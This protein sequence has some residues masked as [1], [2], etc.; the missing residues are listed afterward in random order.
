MEY[1]LV[2]GA[3]SALHGATRDTQDVDILVQRTPAN[4]DRLG[5]ALSEL[6]ARLRAEGL[7][8]EVA[9]A[10]PRR[11]D[12]ATLER[13]EIATLRT[14]CGDLDVLADI[15]GQG[16]RRFTY[17]DLAPDAL[18]VQASPTLFVRLASVQAIV[19]SKEWADRPKDREALPELRKIAEQTMGRPEGPGREAGTDT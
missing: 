11:W 9:Q 3:A 5:V 14:D 6:N 17:D 10:L 19:A 7:S 18:E 12:G 8:D 15:P 13:M 1:L 16:G 4:L 2:G